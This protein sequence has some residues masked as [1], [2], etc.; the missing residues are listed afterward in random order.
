MI[1]VAL[2]GFPQS[3]KTTVFKA[4][5]EAGKAEKEEAPKDSFHI[6]GVKV[7]D[8]RLNLLT[9]KINPKK[10]TPA[11]I[12]FID[13]HLAPSKEK[14]S[15]SFEHSQESDALVLVIRDFEDPSVPHPRQS[16]D[17]KR[18]IIDLE[19]ELFVSDLAK[20]QNRIQRLEAD[21][22][23]GHKE[24]EKELTLMKKLQKALDKEVPLR[25]LSLSKE[26]EL[27]IRGFEFLTGKRQLV[28]L[29][30]D[31]SK[32]NIPPAKD[33]E[34]L[35]RTK[36]FSLMKFSAKIEAELEEL[37]E[38]EREEFLKSYNIQELARDRFIKAVYE[39]L[40]I[41]TFF[42]TK[43]GLLK[44]WT[45]REGTSAKEAAGKIH[46][47]IERGFIK[48]EVVNFKDLEKEN[49]DFHLAK[50]KGLIKLEAKDYLVKEGDIIDFKFNV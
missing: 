30:V 48:A 42:T 28:L 25:K 6:A 7:P 41:I 38:D 47:D 13:E 35:T 37:G 24:L 29:N 15:L 11:E 12:V 10:V 3:G 18:D 2:I 45:V 9:K 50:Q 40:E 36:D 21:I 20:V 17:S 33:M 39:L 4:L 32:I 34:E 43:G 5:S 8:E 16:I 27:L 14:K 49:F 44:A 1:K 19:T 46:S 26:E 31:E 22:K 23:K